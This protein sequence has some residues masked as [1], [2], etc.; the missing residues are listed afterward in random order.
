MRIVAPRAATRPP[1]PFRV[2]GEGGGGARGSRRKKAVQA[3]QPM[4]DDGVDGATT[5]VSRA[6]SDAVEEDEFDLGFVHEAAAAASCWDTLWKAWLRLV[7]IDEKDSSHQ[8][9]GPFPF[10][11]SPGFFQTRVSPTQR[12]TRLCDADTQ[13]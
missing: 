7:P 6:C 13:N 2:S 5:S 11:F 9:S 10:P 8:S 3:S 4:D 1:M 12:A